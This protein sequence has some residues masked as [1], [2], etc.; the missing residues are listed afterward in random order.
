MLEKRTFN[1]VVVSADKPEKLK[2]DGIPDKV[3]SYDGT[4]LKI[5]LSDL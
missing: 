1:V 2:F 3:I 4:E 5:D